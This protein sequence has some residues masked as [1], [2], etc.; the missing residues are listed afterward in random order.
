MVYD[1]NSVS[2]FKGNMIGK[3]LDID[4]IFNVG[5][6]KKGKLNINKNKIKGISNQQTKEFPNCHQCFLKYNCSGLCPLRNYEYSGSVEEPNPKRC[7]EVK[8]INRRFITYLALKE[9][10]YRPS[11]K[12]DGLRRNIKNIK[13]NLGPKCNNNCKFC[14]LLSKKKNIKDKGLEKLKIQIK[15]AIGCDQIV[16][17]GGEVTLYNDLPELVKYARNKGFK[18]IEIETNGRRLFYKKYCQK[19]IDSGVNYF[20][21]NLHGPNAETHDSLT[22]VQGS[23]TQT[24]KGIKNVIS[25]DQNIIV[26]YI[27][28]KQ[29]YRKIPQTVDFL[30]QLGVSQVQFSF[31]KTTEFRGD[32]KKLAKEL[33]P[34]KKEIKP[35]LQKGI[36]KAREYKIEIF[37]KDII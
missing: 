23:F 25:M 33:K 22:N 34:L 15:N 16:F 32:K 37:T 36:K 7:I 3:C 35:Y 11:K 24:V 1:E 30:F 14:V 4:N 27:V 12:Y 31:I 26:N 21:I 10:G 5:C 29:N 6:Y 18:L 28:T 19:L 13:I 20:K 8:K 2:L 9:I 17:T